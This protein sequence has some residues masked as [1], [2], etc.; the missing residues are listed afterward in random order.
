M[1]HFIVLLLLSLACAS[2]RVFAQQ[3]EEFPIGV[4]TNFV[5][6]HL[7]SHLMHDSLHLTWVEG[8]TG[9][10]SQHYLD[11]NPA[12]LKTIAVRWGVLDASISQHMPYEAEDDPAQG[13]DVNMWNYFGTRNGFVPQGENFVQCR[14]GIE[15]I[16]Y[17]V[18]HPRPND[19]F[20]N[21]NA[22]NFIA[23]FNMAIQKGQNT[24]DTVAV[25]SVYTYYNGGVENVFTRTLRDGDFAAGFPTYYEFRLDFNINVCDPPC[26]TPDSLKRGILTGGMALVASNIRCDSIDIRVDWRGYRTTWLDYVITDD[27]PA[28]ALF[29]GW[30][31]AEIQADVQD[32]L[33]DPQGQNY[34]MQRLYVVDEPFVPYFLAI[35][36]IDNRL[37]T[38]GLNATRG[39]PNYCNK[40]LV[41]ELQQALYSGCNPERIAGR[42][43]RH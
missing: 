30:R 11:N 5:G 10:A 25:L 27:S 15:P 14:V 31:D 19:E 33:N 12:G 41:R 28:D 35:K 18:R 40:R 21:D 29:A 17:M 7:D 39:R 16:G 4:Y 37:P 42:L 24:T 26:A 34:H 9:W 43:L 36:Y 32:Y 38:L 3:Q 1:K 13:N 20:R 2:F 22:R 6:D 23:K 8:N